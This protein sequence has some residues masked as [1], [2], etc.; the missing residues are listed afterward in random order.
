MINC[1]PVTRDQMVKNVLMINKNKESN[2]KE[3]LKINELP[4][5]KDQVV[6]SELKT[7]DLPEIK[8]MYVHSNGEPKGND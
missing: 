6:K 3:V 1:L 4:K 7:D 8:N 5:M 2:C